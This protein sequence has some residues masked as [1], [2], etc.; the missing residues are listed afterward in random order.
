[1]SDTFFPS[2]GNL[3]P[4]HEAKVNMNRQRRD[5]LAASLGHAVSW[6]GAV[7]L[8]G[9]VASGN[10]P[11][12]ARD[13]IRRTGPPRFTLGL[14]A[15]SLRND[16]RYM[17]GK[18]RQP[19]GDGPP[20]DMIGFLDYC[21][22]QR[23]D[24]AELTGYFFPPNA[25][26]ATFRRVKKAAF[27]RGMAIAGTAIGNNFTVGRGPRLDQE[28][29]EAVRWID[30][31]VWMGAPHIRFFAGTAA[32]LAEHPDRM[33]E[34]IE[35]IEH[36]AEHAARRGVVIGIENHGRLSADQMLEIMRRIESPWVG[37]NLDTGNFHSEDPYADLRRCA[38]FAVNVQV[39]SM[40]KSAS[41]E[42]YP[43]D[44]GRIA[45]ILGEAGYQGHVVLEYEE[46]NPYEGIPEALGR[47]RESLAA[48]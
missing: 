20:L 11:A 32:Q 27:L 9:V 26:R 2:D 3:N 7:S 37:I 48:V 35:A 44:F 33:T 12:A 29:S 30:R 5:F 38:P 13:P 47:L 21:V 4:F 42:E 17:R 43:A 1:M 41:G 40:M 36:C 15:Y 14:A 10:S 46:E 16:F 25:N 23:C 6:G 18:E 34:A 19:A 39:K 45:A 22:A 28:I 24:S 8:A 31:A